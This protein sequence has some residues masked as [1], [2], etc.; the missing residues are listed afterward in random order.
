MGPRP[1]SWQRPLDTGGPRDLR[2][3]GRTTSRPLLRRTPRGPPYLEG[4]ET[5]LRLLRSDLCVLQ[6]MTSAPQPL[7]G[8]LHFDP[9]IVPYRK[10]PQCVLCS[11]SSSSR[12]SS[13]S[14]D[15]WDGVPKWPPQRT[16]SFS[17]P[18]V[19][20]HSPQACG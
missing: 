7:A 19:P 11:Q 14:Q 18:S 1:V 15:S 2:G 12:S 6:G 17:Q 4:R 9:A 13:S 5:H 16:T 8:G 10:D 20:P 3:S